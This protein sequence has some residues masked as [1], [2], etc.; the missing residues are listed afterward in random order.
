MV[1]DV[2]P[3]CPTDGK[4]NGYRSSFHSEK[5]DLQ[6]SFQKTALKRTSASPN[7]IGTVFEPIDEFKGDVIRMILYFATRYESKLSSLKTMIF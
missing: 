6:I 2:T 3:C 5:W 4:V 7:Y 1:S